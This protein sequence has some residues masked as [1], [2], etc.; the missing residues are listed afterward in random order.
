MKNQNTKISYFYT[1]AHKKFSEELS[2]KQKI[3]CKFPC[4]DAGHVGL[5][6]IVLKDWHKFRLPE[7]KAYSKEQ[8]FMESSLFIQ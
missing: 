2:G 4:F 1:I 6:S 3:M 5:I 7:R 8:N